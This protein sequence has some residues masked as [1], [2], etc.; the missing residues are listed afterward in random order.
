MMLEMALK[1]ET[2]RY[3]IR[4]EYVLFDLLRTVKNKSCDPLKKVH[5]WF[6]GEEGRDTGGLTREMWRLFS[7]E[8]Q[9][10]CE[11][12]KGCLLIKHDATKLQVYNHYILWLFCYL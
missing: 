8:V 3:E 10:I 9:R 1:K 5:M 6:V 2:F 12:K 4:R 7:I 11:G